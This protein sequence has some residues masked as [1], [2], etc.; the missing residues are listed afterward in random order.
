M[1]VD[2]LAFAVLL[3]TLWA[4]HNVGDHIAQT[5]HEAAHKAHDWFAMVGHVNSYQV[6]QALTT[7]A[8]LGLTGLRCRPGAKLAGALFSGVSHAFI[9]RRWP[10]RWLLEHTAAPQFAR[11]LAPV[12][13]PYA[14]DQAC[15][16]ACLL[17]TALIMAVR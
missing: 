16:H 12:N 14:A 5:D 7:D 13:G 1:K 3:P 8:V 4:A 17:I 10:V 2:P 15:H 6:V 9:D 11:M